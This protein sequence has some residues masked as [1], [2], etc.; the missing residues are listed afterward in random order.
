M[1]AAMKRLAAAHDLDA[2]GARLLRLTNNAVFVLPAADAVIRIARSHRPGDRV[3]KGVELAS[4]FE[5]ID[6]PTIRL[7]GPGAQPVNVDGLQA[8]VWQYLPP[9]E[10]LTP[11]D[12]GMALKQFHALGLPPFRLPAWDPVGDARRR[13]TDAEDLDVTDRR[14]LMTWCAELEP[15]IAELQHRQA[16]TLVHGDAHVGNLLRDG[17]RPVFCDFD[18]ICSGPWQADLAAVAV[19]EHRFGRPGAHRALAGSYG[20]D[21]RTDPDWPLLRAARELKMIVAAVP[22]LASSPGVAREFRVR[23]NTVMSGDEVTRWTPFADLPR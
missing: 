21:V 10:P 6:A 16:A 18:P 12:L 23:L 5:S 14:K 13:L 22:L 20:Y 9:G 3:K 11:T 15:R 17:Q 7:A 1:T 8:T 2:S 19:G 4:W